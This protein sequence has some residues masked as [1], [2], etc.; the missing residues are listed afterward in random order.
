MVIAPEVKDALQQEA[1]LGRHPDALDS[2]F[3]AP[4]LYVVLPEA[5]SLSTCKVVRYDVTHPSPTAV[6]T[7]IRCH[8][9]EV[10]KVCVMAEVAEVAVRQGM[11]GG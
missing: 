3:V 9:V 11:R 10:A 2:L 6:T 7:I 1:L 5:P 8:S 4:Y